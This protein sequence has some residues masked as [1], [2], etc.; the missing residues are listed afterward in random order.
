MQCGKFTL[1]SIACAQCLLWA[2]HTL[3]QCGVYNFCEVEFVHGLVLGVTLGCV[4]YALA[5]CWGEHTIQYVGSAHC[6]ALGQ[7]VAQIP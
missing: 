7:Q 5:Y 6:A 1:C 4:K 3:Q 2:E